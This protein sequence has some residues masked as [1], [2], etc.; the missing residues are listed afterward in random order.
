MTNGEN[1][2]FI[3]HSPLIQDNPDYLVICNY[4]IVTFW[5]FL[6]LFIVFEIPCYYTF[7]TSD[8]VTWNLLS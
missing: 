3:E 7:M 6:C 8:L 2:D 1:N 5:H 4:W